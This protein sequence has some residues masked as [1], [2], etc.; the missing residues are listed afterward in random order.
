MDSKPTSIEGAKLVS[1]ST[2]PIRQM[3]GFDKRFQL[4]KAIDHRALNWIEELTRPQLDEQLQ[5]YLDQF[6]SQFSFKRR[7]MEIH[8]PADG[9]AAIDT[10]IFNFSIGV[11][12]DPDD[13]SVIVW[14][15]EIS[16]ILDAQ[17]IVGPEFESCFFETP[18][19]LEVAS[20]EPF[21]IVE[22]IDRIEDLEV[23]TITLGYDKDLTSCNVKIADTKGE[24]QVN[25]AGFSIGHQN[26]LSPGEMINALVV[27]QNWMKATLEP[28]LGD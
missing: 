27:Y 5:F 24:L 13:L 18:W 8:G 26:G 6:R 3:P 25:E 12:L 21:D 23:D 4:P 11:E 10:P 15:R 20:S 28:A 9:R 17:K 19:K 2:F 7:Q 14:R 22:L 16:Q 1:L